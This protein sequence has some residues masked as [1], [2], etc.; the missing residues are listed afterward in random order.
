MAYWKASYQSKLYK[1]VFGEGSEKEVVILLHYYQFR[2]VQAK[3][4]SRNNN[5]LQVTEFM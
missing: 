5:R 4:K 2:E 3:N 1:R